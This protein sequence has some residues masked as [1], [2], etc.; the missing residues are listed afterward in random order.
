MA[1]LENEFSVGSGGD[2]DI[3]VELAEYDWSLNGKS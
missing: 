2:G 3:I 1:V